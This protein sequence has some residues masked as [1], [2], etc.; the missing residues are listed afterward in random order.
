MI[1]GTPGISFQINNFQLKLGNQ[2][3]LTLQPAA[4]QPEFPPFELR[5]FARH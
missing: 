2:L 1:L 4:L 3:P 5:Q